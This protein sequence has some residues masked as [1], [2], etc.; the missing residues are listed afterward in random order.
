MGGGRGQA[1][2]EAGVRQLGVAPGARGR[3]GPGTARR[4]GHRGARGGDGV[5][6]RQAHLADLS[7]HQWH[8]RVAAVSVVAGAA[9][10]A[11]VRRRRAG[12]QPRPP[13]PAPHRCV[14]GTCPFLSGVLEIALYL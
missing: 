3:G 5:Q 9:R 6:L 14:P 2:R 12:Q 13:R 8:P 10:H 11:G 7:R 1:A 4:R